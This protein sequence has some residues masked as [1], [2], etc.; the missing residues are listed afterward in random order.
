MAPQP[1][2]H[3]SNIP[4]DLPDNSTLPPQKRHFIW[5]ETNEPHLIRKQAIMKKYGAEVNKLMGCDPTLKWKIGFSVVVQVLLAWY[6][7]RLSW[8]L[9][10]LMAWSVGGTINHSLTL[11]MH[12]VSH[13]LA[14][15]IRNKW[16][17]RYL[18]MVANLPL[19]IPAFAS[20][21]RYH[22]DHHKCVVLS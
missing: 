19:G 22:Q 6:A 13:D 5:M 7:T 21:R 14:F 10:V 4:R 16:A 11:A 20:F 18:G 8:P 12:E 1:E 9:L 17:N 15:S 3:T 2:P